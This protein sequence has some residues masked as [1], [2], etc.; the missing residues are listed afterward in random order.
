MET[1]ISNLLIGAW[2]LLVARCIYEQQP[3][4]QGRDIVQM[5]L[6]CNLRY[7]KNNRTKVWLHLC[8][9]VFKITC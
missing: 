3:Q 2:S 6:K 7:S 4:R 8:S 9:L 5:N 1:A